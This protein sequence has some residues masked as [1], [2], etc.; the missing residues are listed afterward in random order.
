MVLAPRRYSARLRLPPLFVWRWATRS[1]MTVLGSLLVL[2]LIAVAALG[3][4]LVPFHPTLMNRNDLLSAPSVR[5]PFGT[6]EFGRDILSRVVYGMRISF[7]VGAASL[8]LGGLVGVT[9]GLAAGYFGGITDSVT[10]RFWDV[11][12]ALP[13]A[14]LGIV[15]AAALGPGVHSVI[16]AG[17]VVGMPF[18]SRIVRAR[19]LL[20]KELDYVVAARSLGAGHL[21][22]VWKHV[23]PNA[24][25]PILVQSSNTV[26]VAIL[27]EATLSFLGLGVQ[28]PTPS[29]GTMLYEAKTVLGLAPWYPV[30]P[31]LTL[32]L[33]IVSLNMVAD[34]LQEEAR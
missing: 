2:V 34:G 31:G 26:G 8:V 20:E 27:L 7:A 16:F 5:F 32:V 4:M 18:F 17:A 9:T 15:A 22:I 10:M 1:H 6:D 3:P 23:L 30:F 14:L 12:L 19:V 21:R 28:P 25:K 13:G 33:L 11:L 24:T 29:L